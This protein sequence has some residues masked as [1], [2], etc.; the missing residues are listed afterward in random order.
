MVD[1]RMPFTDAMRLSMKTVNEKGFLM[2]LIFLLLVSVIPIMIIEF[3]S[4]IMP[5]AHLLKIFIPPLQVGCLASL[6]IDQFKELEK[7]TAPKHEEENTEAPPVTLPLAEKTG[8]QVEDES[9]QSK[10][11]VSEETKSSDQEDTES[12]PDENVIN[13]VPD[14]KDATDS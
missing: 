13:E 9:K 1:R 5:F 14:Q 10:Q 7:E 3:I 8:D 6:Y 2:H 12:L 4:A 11:P